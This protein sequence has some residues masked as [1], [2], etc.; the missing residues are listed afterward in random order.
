MFKKI[1]KSVCASTVG[2]SHDPLFLT[3]SSSAMKTP[4]N[5][6][7]NPDDPNPADKG[8]IKMEYFPDHLNTPSVGA[9][10]KKDIRSV[11]VPSNK[12]DKGN[13]AVFLIS[14]YILSATPSKA[15]SFTLSAQ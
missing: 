11:R 5:T 3:P 14:P 4:E 1:S 6:E 2:V 8:Y 15:T 10:S 12:L 13:S 7:E 9:V